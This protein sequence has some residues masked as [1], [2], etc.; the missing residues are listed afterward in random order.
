MMSGVEA[1][2]TGPVSSA[3]AAR[4]ASASTPSTSGAASSASLAPASV[5]WM[6]R[7]TRSKSTMP[8]SRSSFLTWV[9]TVGWPETERLRRAGDALV[10]DHRTEASQMSQLHLLSS[11]Q[12]CIV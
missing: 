3:S 8:S 11:P 12:Q 5:G 6:G 10:L 4:T 1:T 2:E 7:R 9:V